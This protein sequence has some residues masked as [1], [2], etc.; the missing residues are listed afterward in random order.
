MLH[1]RHKYQYLINDQ[2][3]KLITALGNLLDPCQKNTIVYYTIVYISYIFF[4][5]FFQKQTI[6][7]LH[8]AI[9]YSLAMMKMDD[10]IDIWM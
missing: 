8:F 2:A 3:N 4:P 9:L 10:M 1:V 6:Q 5:I 7:L